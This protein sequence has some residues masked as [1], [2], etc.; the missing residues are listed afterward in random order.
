MLTS[1]FFLPIAS[2]DADGQP[3]RLLGT[4]WVATPSG[5]LVTCRHVVDRVDGSGNEI[6]P[7]VVDTANQD[8]C[9]I[10]Q[11][12]FSE[13]QSVDLA[14]LPEAVDRGGACLPILDPE[15]LPLGVDTSCYGYYS[16]HNGRFPVQGGLFKGALSS[17]LPGDRG[18]RKCLLPY[19]VIEGMSGSAITTYRHGTKVAAVA[20]GN[21]SQRVTAYEVTE[22]HDGERHYKE[23]TTRIVETGLGHHA[24][25]LIDFLTEV[26]AGDFVVSADPI[27]IAGLDGET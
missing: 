22:V 26:E 7:Y 20:Y 9:S 17:V 6:A 2:V 5:G 19:A 11:G 25:T 24:Q 15:H 10:R 12:F 8:T 3:D 4:A 23:T 14:Y 16:T 27:R 21:E 13:D 18:S 1:T